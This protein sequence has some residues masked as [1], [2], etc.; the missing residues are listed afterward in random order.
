MSLNVWPFCFVTTRFK[1]RTEFVGVSFLLSRIKVYRLQPPI[2][3]HWA[4]AK[5]PLYVPW[6][7]IGCGGPTSS[8]WSGRQGEPPPKLALALDCTYI[9][10]A[11][12]TLNNVNW[13]GQNWILCSKVQEPQRTLCNQ[14]CYFINSLCLST[15][16]FLSFCCIMIWL[17]YY[18]SVARNWVSRFGLPPTLS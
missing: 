9:I 8:V 2:L 11:C 1:E 7:V 14:P 4:Q 6:Y 17:C 18:I 10:C 3:G 12:N 5:T 16:P 15:C 13:Q